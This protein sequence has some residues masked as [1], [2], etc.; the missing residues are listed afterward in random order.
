MKTGRTEKITTQK[1][2]I[3]IFIA[4]IFIKIWTKYV[5]EHSKDKKLNRFSTIG[6]IFFPLL[7][8]SLSRTGPSS[9]KPYDQALIMVRDTHDRFLNRKFLS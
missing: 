6:H 3:T 4:P 5:S 1:F 8:M 7:C 2:W 9:L